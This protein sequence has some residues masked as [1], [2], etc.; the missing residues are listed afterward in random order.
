MH[1][2]AVEMFFTL[3]KFTPLVHTHQTTQ[4]ERLVVKLLNRRK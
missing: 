3:S 1:A 4:D 2:N